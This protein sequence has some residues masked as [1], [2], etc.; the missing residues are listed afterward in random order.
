ML[1]D[2][3]SNIYNRGGH[4]TDGILVK[5]H[6]NFNKHIPAIAVQYKRNQMNGFYKTFDEAGQLISDRTFCNGFLHGISKFYDENENLIREDE[7]DDGKKIKST[8]YIPS[9]P[10]EVPQSF[11]KRPRRRYS[12]SELED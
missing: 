6:Y 5:N 9:E 12:L 3:T 11:A 10:Q 1:F 8:M 7:Y 4:L 2:T